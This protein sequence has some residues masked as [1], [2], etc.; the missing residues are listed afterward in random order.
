MSILI[1]NSARNAEVPYDEW[2]G[3]S[4]EPL[5]LLC[6]PRQER[7]SGAYQFVKKFENY[8]TNS[9]VEATAL[10][11]HEKYRYH[12]VVAKA[13]ADLLRA[14][15]LRDVV[16]LAGQGW[17]SARAYRDKTVMKS[18][19]Q[20]AGIPTPVFQRIETAFDLLGFVKRH[21]YPVVVKPVDGSGAAGVEALRGPADLERLLAGGL[22][23]NLEVEQ[24]IE[25]EVFHVDGLVLNGQTV[26]MQPSRYLNG[27]CLAY[28]TDGSCGSY[29]LPESNPL[30]A[31]LSTFTQRI[32]DALP[33]P[34]TF[35]FHAE[36]FRTPSDELVFCEIA[37]R[38]GGVRINETVRQATAVDM[39]RLWIRAQCGIPVDAAQVRRTIAAQKGLAGWLVV[40][41]RN[42]VLQALPER[43]PEWVTEYRKNAAPGTNFAG[44]AYARRKAGDYIVSIIVK[45][46]TEAQIEQRLADSMRW[47][48]EEIRWAQP[49]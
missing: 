35:T 45:G 20:K 48:H 49:G 34:P 10:E 31:R 44:P 7:I 6:S 47:L 21:G 33:S 14:G 3:E 26:L 1:L 19:T 46:D 28:K 32:L 22:A 38:T 43:A 30:R 24:Y 40:P 25:G 29:T 17:E 23:Q 41:P 2:L 13:E 11:L 8:E 15:K 16:G 37:S 4:G 9:C 36:I 12:T 39:D 27:G 5:L 18:Y 42:A